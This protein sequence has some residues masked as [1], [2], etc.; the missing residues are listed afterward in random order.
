MTL[1]CFSDEDDDVALIVSFFQV[2][3]LIDGVDLAHVFSNRVMLGQSLT[4]Y[5][6]CVFEAIKVEGKL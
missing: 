3:G 5:G 4:V 1:H 2:S 6:S